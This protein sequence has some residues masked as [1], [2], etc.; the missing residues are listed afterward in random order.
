MFSILDA[1]FDQEFKD[2]I[3][4]F[5]VSIPQSSTCYATSTT[6]DIRC[7]SILLDLCNDIIN[8]II[9]G[10][11]INELSYVIAI[12]IFND[13]ICFVELSMEQQSP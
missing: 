4:K 12:I 6:V 5:F 13:L 8:I 11:T 3:S 1:Q 2:F 9:V 10:K 7:K